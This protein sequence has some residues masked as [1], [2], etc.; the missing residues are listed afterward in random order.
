MGRRV[1]FP[2]A[3]RRQGA[4]VPSAGIPL[5]RTL[6]LV[7]LAGALTFAG[8]C[9]WTGLYPR[10]GL[11]PQEDPA[12]TAIRDEVLD[13]AEYRT[14]QLAASLSDLEAHARARQNHTTHWTWRGR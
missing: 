3:I 11:G 9:W 8:L 7:L 4:T 2:I 5:E 1:G 12:L 10:R 6:G 14:A 13:E